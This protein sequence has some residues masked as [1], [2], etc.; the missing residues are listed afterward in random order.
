MGLSIFMLFKIKVLLVFFIL[1]IYLMVFLVIFVKVEI[2]E[3][4]V[5]IGFVYK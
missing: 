5:V 2:C 3:F 4:E 1:F